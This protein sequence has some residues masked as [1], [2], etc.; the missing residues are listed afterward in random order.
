LSSL[1]LPFTIGLVVAVLFAL[2][3]PLVFDAP[4][5]ADDPRAWATFLLLLTSP[6]PFVTGIIG[7]WLSFAWK[8][9]RL[10]LMLMGLPLLG[11]G[12]I[13]LCA[14]YGEGF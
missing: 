5:S 14:R 3:S 6:I 7:G 10:A 2:V 9:Y 4:G 1:T 12:V 11:G 13:L 8:R